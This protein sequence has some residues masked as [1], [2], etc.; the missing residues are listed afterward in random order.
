MTKA[1]ENLKKDIEKIEDEDTIEKI[2][3]FILGIL[4]Q[5][6]SAE[7]K[8]ETAGIVRRE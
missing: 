3:I 7:K 2:R 8:G 1:Q 5:Q 6:G 4:A